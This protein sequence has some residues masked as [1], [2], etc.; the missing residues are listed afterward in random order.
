MHLLH[1]NI[2]GLPHVKANKVACELREDSDQPEQFAILNLLIEH[3][4]LLG[5]VTKKSVHQVKYCYIQIIPWSQ[6]HI[7]Q[8]HKMGLQ[9]WD[10]SR[11]PSI[12]AR[13]PTT[14]SIH[15]HIHCSVSTKTYINLQWPSSRQTLTL[16]TPIATK[17]VCFSRLVK[18]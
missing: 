13:P 6:P 12:Q 7:V 15:R 1:D 17:V 9:F 3:F 8:G 10:R 4:K 18:C 16:Y 2:T 5:N 14:H 11:S